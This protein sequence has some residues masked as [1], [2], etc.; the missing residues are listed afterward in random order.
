M[1]TLFALIFSGEEK[2]RSLLFSL[3]GAG[4]SF[5]SQSSGF[6]GIDITNLALPTTA[7]TIGQH[8]PKS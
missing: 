2:L 7:V 1:S 6:I 4:L 5:S 8:Q 3:A